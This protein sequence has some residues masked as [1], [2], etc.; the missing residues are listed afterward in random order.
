M[1]NPT[2]GKRN[3][4]SMEIWRTDGGSSFMNTAAISR[5]Y[6]GIHFRSANNDGLTAGVA[7]G[8]WTFARYMRPKGNRARK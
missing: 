4:S 1:A 8:E 6:G 2:A 3:A 5:L 7:I